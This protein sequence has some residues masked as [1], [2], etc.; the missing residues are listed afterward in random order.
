VEIPDRADV[1][2]LVKR[3]L[4]GDSKAFD[5][6]TEQCNSLVYAAALRVVGDRDAAEDIT[7]ETLV[8]AYL[9]LDTLEDPT[10]F[11]SWARSIAVNQARN[12]LTRRS[13]KAQ[14]L[15]SP[16]HT[17]NGSGE[18][19]VGLPEA[20]IDAHTPESQY[21]HGE[22]SGVVIDA[23]C[24]L[25][26]ADRDLLTQF[27]CRGRSYREI[28]TSLA[29]TEQIVQGRL[30]AARERL[31]GR[32]VEEAEELLNEALKGHPLPRRLHSRRR[33]RSLPRIDIHTDAD[34]VLSS[35]I[36]RI[37]KVG[38]TY[39]AWVL[40]RRAS[41]AEVFSHPQQII[42]LTSTD[43][44]RW[45]NRGPVFELCMDPS[46]DRFDRCEIGAFC[47]LNYGSAYRMWYTGH[48]HHP[49]PGA[50][51]I[52]YAIS[53]DGLVWQRVP[54]LGQGGAVLDRGTEE[55]PD[56]DGVQSP[57]VLW[58]GGRYRMWY[59]AREKGDDPYSTTSTIHIAYAESTDGIVWAKHGPVLS[60]GEDGEFDTR[61][62][63]PGCV[64]RDGDQ[65]RML[66]TVDDDIRRVYAIG[67]AISP[68]GIAWTKQ[69]RVAGQESA[70][71]QAGSPSVVWDEEERR[72][73]YSTMEGIAC[74]EWDNLLKRVGGS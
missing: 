45:T 61:W 18:W 26:K 74:V 56:G 41:R 28:A 62:T 13:G 14:S 55:E 9:R 10:K 42:H 15:D 3:S 73:W 69:G 12:W 50:P 51:R 57:F 8:Q 58:D 68:D 27:Y 59:G 34:E 21:L 22:R 4:E 1:G 52:G 31:K 23:L 40:S 66:Y 70:F 5:E 29:V 11:V 24:S 53:E 65:Y 32:V 2:Q 48:M 64:V 35:G 36:P 54:G 33:R 25:P 67:H 16:P 60:P 47:V 20:L 30:Q 71:D 37:I 6:L 44:L 49:Q 39:C 7:Q 38:S 19:H 17:D 43:G 72:V 63:Y 46:S